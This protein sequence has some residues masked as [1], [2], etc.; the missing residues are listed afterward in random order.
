MHTFAPGD[1]GFSHYTMKWGTVEEVRD[2]DDGWFTVRNDDGTKDF[3]NA[4]RFNTPQVA[5]R[6]GYGA[7][8]QL[9]ANLTQDEIL[10]QLAR[11]GE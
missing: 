10:E 1:R 7:D 4:D 11:L 3:L 5:G 2:T 8:P 9:L 6:Y